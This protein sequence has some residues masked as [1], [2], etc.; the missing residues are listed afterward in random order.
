MAVKMSR[1][2]AR[3]I[4]GSVLLALP[5][6]NIPALNQADPGPPIP[7]AFSGA[8]NSGFNDGNSADN[9]AQI[10][11]DEF[12]GDPQLN[13]LIHQAM[14]NN[15]ELKSL[16]QE[17]EVARN[18]VLARSGAYLPFVTFGA[19][20]GIEKPSLFTPAGA[21][22]KNVPF[23]PGQGFPEPNPDFGLGFNFLWQLD[24]WR[25]YRNARD[26]AC[27][28]FLAAAER[29]NYFVTKLIAEVA[30][31]YYTLMALDKR[32][33]TLDKTI[34]LQT[35]SLKVAVSRKEAGRGTELPVQRFQ[36]DVQKNQS[37]KLIVKQEIVEN[38]NRINFLLNRFPQ[39]VQRNSDVFFDLTLQSL[40]LGIPAQLLQNRPD[41]RQAERELSAAGLDVLVA[42]AHFYPRVDITGGIGYSAFNTKYLFVSPE[43][44]VYNVAGD[45]V[46]PVINRRAIQAEYQGANAK[47]LAAVYN[48]Q[49]VILNAFTEVINRMSKV[50]NYGQSI[51]IKKQQLD[52]LVNA[53]K[54]ATRLFV[55]TRVEYV[56]VLLAQRD[57]MEARMVLIDTKN[58]Q[59][60]AIVNTYQALGG[61]DLL[62]RATVDATLIQAGFVDP[63]QPPPAVTPVPERLPAPPNQV[64]PAPGAVNP[65]RAD[66]FPVIPKPVEPLGA[67]PAP[68]AP[69][70]PDAP[71]VPAAPGS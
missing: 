70:V 57:L 11:V 45:L 25:E 53:V 21:V 15:L 56:E 44:L 42:R 41:I 27:Q 13:G 66:P 33:E 17:V 48:Y 4:A 58:E 35:Q 60:A 7:G 71:A 63:S 31:K 29:R 34:D 50:Q 16:N 64:Q 43:S 54:T 14:G 10:G 9:S 59:L 24:I 2:F 47:Q 40:S 28:R 36:A 65:N 55:A 20:T 6:C 46:A 26:A 39:P 23:L 68:A 3:A 38:E 37:E 1:I 67:P 8:N 49:K 69:A 18:E 5:S 52:Q 22:E 30:E 12:F 62:G 32:I 19:R 61:G 51:E